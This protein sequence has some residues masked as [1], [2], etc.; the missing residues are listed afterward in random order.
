MH[1]IFGGETYYASG[2]VN[3]FICMANKSE[4]INLAK[5]LIGK[6]IIRYEDWDEKR[7]F[8]MEETIEWTHVATQEG[9]LIENFGKSYSYNNCTKIIAYLEK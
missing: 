2:G 8:K 5:E 1:M 3:D 6:K 9:V 4:S 7:E